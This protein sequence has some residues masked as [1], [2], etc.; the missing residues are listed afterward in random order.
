MIGF[1]DEYEKLS[2]GKGIVGR[3]IRAAIEAGYGRFDFMR[4]AEDLQGALR[5]RSAASRDTTA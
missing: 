3:A 5:E 2:P 4:G 1:D